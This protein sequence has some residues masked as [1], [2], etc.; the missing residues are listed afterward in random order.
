MNH[1]DSDQWFVITLVRDP[2]A[3]CVSEFFDLL[4]QTIPC[5]E[6]RFAAGNLKAGYL[7]DRLP[8]YPGNETVF[9]W[10]DDQMRSV[11]GV[12]V[13][14]DECEVKEGYRVYT[15]GKRP[16]L[17]IRL[18]DVDWAFAPAIEEFL[19]VSGVTLARENVADD[20][21]GAALYREL[22]STPLPE[23]YVDRMYRSAVARCFYSEEELSRFKLRWTGR[24]KSVMRPG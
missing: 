16:V 3:R 12:D 24:S 21:P 2:V 4:D 14:E 9:T 1:Y 20:R 8:Y 10:F 7:V 19:G 6:D 5:W 22:Q 18:E 15:T 23:D 17:L 11:F 13:F